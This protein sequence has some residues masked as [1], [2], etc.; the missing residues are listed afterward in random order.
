MKLKVKGNQWTLV[1]LR[2][3]VV[4]ASAGCDDADFDRTTLVYPKRK[5]TPAMCG[6]KSAYRAIR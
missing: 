3:Q 4:V 6:C 5:T 1:H 2:R